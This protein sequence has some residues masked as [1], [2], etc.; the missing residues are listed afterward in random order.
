MVDIFR[1]HHYS[2]EG[3]DKRIYTFCIPMAAILDFSFYSDY[4]LYDTAHLFWI[5]SYFYDI[6][7]I[8]CNY[9]LAI[10]S[11]M[12]VDLFIHHGKGNSITFS[13]VYNCQ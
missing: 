12:Y 5:S 8:C 4:L 1:L 11:N 10:F 7:F 13:M 6:T 3:E 9:I 2:S